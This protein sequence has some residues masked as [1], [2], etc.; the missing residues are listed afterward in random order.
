SPDSPLT[1]SV[2][3][4]RIWNYHFGQGIAPAPSDFGMMGGRPSHPELLDWLATEF[5]HSGWDVKHMHKLIV[6]SS[7]YRQSSAFNEIAANEDPKDKLLWRYPRERLEG[8]VI[9][10]SALAVAGLLNAK[11]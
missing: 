7:T 9:R 11:M 5:V 2:M 1:A 8:E 6:M 10:D 3:V 4:N